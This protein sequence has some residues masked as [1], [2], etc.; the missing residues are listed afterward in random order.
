MHL[1]IYFNNKPLFLADSIDAELEPF[2]HHDD[3]VLVDE[4]SS[5][6]INS[7]IHEMRLD[8]IHAGILQHSDLEELKRAFFRKFTMVPAAGG[9]V[10]NDLKQVLMIKRRGKWDLPKGKLD[11]NE[12]IENCAVR[13]VREETGLMHVTL[14]KP[15]VIT[16]HTYDESGKHILKDTH[17]YLMQAPGTQHFVPQLDEQ[18]SEIEWVDAGKLMHYAENTFPSIRDVLKAAG[19]LG[20]LR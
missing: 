9:L 16:Y 5:P 10:L 15:L 2:A 13:E 18:I 20:T 8:K 4:F 14:A 19:Y 6:A 11:E 17:W 12:T 7:L 3:A 1:K